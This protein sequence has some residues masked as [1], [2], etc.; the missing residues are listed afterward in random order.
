MKKLIYG[1]TIIFALLL[2][3]CEEGESANENTS[4]EEV[5]SEEALHYF[6]E[7]AF[8]NEWDDEDVPIRKWQTD[9]RI[10][11]FGNP[12]PQDLEALEQVVEDINS[13]QS[14]ITL[15]IVEEK[16]DIKLYFVPLQDFSLY[17]LNPTQNNWGLFYYWWNNYA[18]TRATILISTDKPTQIEREHLIREEL[19][20]SLGLVRDSYQYPDSIFYGDW[21]TTTTFAP[22]DKQL[23]KMLYDDRIEP[24]MTEAQVQSIFNP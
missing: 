13:I 1:A 24:G 20:Q 10:Q 6:S 5:T 7:I 23:L 18:I 11:V 21:T 4:E 15:T 3:A 19:T 2:A 8:G 12:S 16:P 14:S 9:P 17:V 22:I